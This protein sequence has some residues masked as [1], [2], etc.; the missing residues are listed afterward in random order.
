MKV[1]ARYR[2]HLRLNSIFKTCLIFIVVIVVLAGCKKDEIVMGNRPP[3]PVEVVTLE[4]GSTY[5]V[6]TWEEAVDPDKDHVYYTVTLEGAIVLKNTLSVDTLTLQNLT[7]SMKYHG[8]LSL[9][10]K[11]NKP[12]DIPFE[13]TTGLNQSPSPFTVTVQRV[14]QNFAEISWSPLKDP[15]N[16]TVY[17]TISI[18]GI[19]IDTRVA[20]DTVFRIENLSHSTTYNGTLVATDNKSSMWR[21]L[22]HLQQRSMPFFL[23]SCSRI[24]MTI[25]CRGSLFAEREMAGTQWPRAS[26]SMPTDMACRF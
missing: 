2:H 12:V 6:I 25:S 9:W 15:E 19:G 23:I 13:F 1:N 20:A 14:G 3:L 18:N 24:S 26:V 8:S 5:A 21:P 11:T 17:Q 4:T 22:S 16:D 10:D 7:P